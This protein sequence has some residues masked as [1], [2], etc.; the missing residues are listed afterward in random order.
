MSASYKSGFP[1][2]S[3][4]LLLACFFGCLFIFSSTYALVSDQPLHENG[5][6]PLDGVQRDRNIQT[7]EQVAIEYYKSHTYEVN[8]VYDCDNMAQDV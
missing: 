2:N 6:D 5:S 8:E 1:K 4:F 3:I 7:C